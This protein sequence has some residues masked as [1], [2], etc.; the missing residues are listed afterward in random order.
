MAKPLKRHPALIPLSQDHHF[1]LLL[2]WKIRQGLNRDVDFQRILNYVKYF[3]DEHLEKH[4][5]SEEDYLFSYLAKND[6]L[7][8]EAEEQHKSLR[9]LFG[10]MVGGNQVERSQLNEFADDLES[11]IRF[12]ER[13]LFPYIQVELMEGDLEEFQVKMDQIHEK[14][15]ENWEDEFWIK[16]K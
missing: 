10:E 16:I 14:V 15:Q 9:A 1:G 2:S 4:F 6:L 8:K 5:Q 12:E 11:H 3:V 13:K 7:R